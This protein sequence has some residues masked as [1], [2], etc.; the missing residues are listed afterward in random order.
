MNALP[1]T[2][3]VGPGP[4][5]GFPPSTVKYMATEAK[6]FKLPWAITAGM[7]LFVL[8]V[9]YEKIVP[10]TVQNMHIA[11]IPVKGNHA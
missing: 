1:P 2:I 9:K 10:R 7:Q 6:P 11:N 3:P 5:N 4:T 8:I